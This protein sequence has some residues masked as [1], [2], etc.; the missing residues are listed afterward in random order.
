M[1]KNVSSIITDKAN[2]LHMIVLW[3]Y[4]RR[5]Q[6][7]ENQVLP[8]HESFCPQSALQSMACTILS[9]CQGEQGSGLCMNQEFLQ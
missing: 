7:D 4:H 6:Y 1:Q 5:Q 3:Y 2:E 8:D 9:A